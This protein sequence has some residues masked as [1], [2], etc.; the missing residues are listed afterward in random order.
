[1]P[2]VRR[3]I[4]SVGGAQARVAVAAGASRGFDELGLEA[5]R[6]SD[7]G[8]RS[9]E[10]GGGV[11][12]GVGL[13]GRQFLLNTEEPQSAVETGDPLDLR[14][15]GGGGRD[16]G[17]GRHGSFVSRLS[18]LLRRLRRVLRSRWT[19]TNTPSVTRQV[20][21]PFL[22]VYSDLHGQ[23]RDGEGDG[24]HRTFLGGSRR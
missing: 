9:V 22:D 23:T 5:A 8:G 13:Q 1:M 7:R 14:G 24:L 18:S 21:A 10:G 16:S 17:G 11:G 2:R 3:G 15:H 20:A 19:D 12:V 4:R 6:G